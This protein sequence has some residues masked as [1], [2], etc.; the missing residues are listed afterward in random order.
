MRYRLDSAR[1]VDDREF[2]RTLAI[3]WSCL[4]FFAA[5]CTAS[6][7]LATHSFAFAIAFTAGT[8]VCAMAALAHWNASAV[9]RR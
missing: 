2:D 3:W 1:S 4:A 6:A 9:H 8:L 5:G 7:V